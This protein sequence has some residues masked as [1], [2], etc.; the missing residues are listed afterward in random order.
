SHAKSLSCAGTRRAT[1][2]LYPF[3]RGGYATERQGPLLAGILE[4]LLAYAVFTVLT[5]QV[6]RIRGGPAAVLAPVPNAKCLGLSLCAFAVVLALHGRLLCR[7][8]WNG[9]DGFPAHR[10]GSV[11]VPLVCRPSLGSGA[12]VARELV[13]IKQEHVVVQ[14][15]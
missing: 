11:L 10:S 14:P 6:T 15:V 13:G 12:V 3:G 2:I 7:A 4:L 9:R 1:G 8:G 5:A